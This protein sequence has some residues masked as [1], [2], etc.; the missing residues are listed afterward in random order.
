MRINPSAWQWSEQPGSGLNSPLPCATAVE[1]AMRVHQTG[2]PGWGMVHSW[3]PGVWGRWRLMVAVVCAGESEIVC[4]TPADKI[5][6]A[7]SMKNAKQWSSR[8]ALSP[9]RSSQHLR[10]CPVF[11]VMCLQRR[12]VNKP[13]PYS[14]MC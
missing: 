6:A 9:S 12:S 1:R 13:A 14:K 4:G 5:I 7:R 3:L 10:H 2:C 11:L 8:I